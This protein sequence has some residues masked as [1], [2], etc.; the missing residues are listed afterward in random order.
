MCGVAGIS[1]KFLLPW[2]ALLNE[3]IGEIR[4]PDGAVELDGSSLSASAECDLTSFWGV[5]DPV[6]WFKGV[7]CKCLSWPM[8]LG[9]PN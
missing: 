5:R 8:A 3:F 7:C 9:P 1:G 6:V 2:C 4:L